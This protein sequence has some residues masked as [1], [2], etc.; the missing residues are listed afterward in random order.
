ML[1]SCEIM[2]GLGNQIFQIF[3]TIAYSIRHNFKFVFP[4]KKRNIDTRMSS[5]YWDNLLKP[6]KIF[7]SNGFLNG[8]M[9]KEPYFKFANIPNFSHITNTLI[10]NG[11]FQSH[12][13]FE[14][15]YKE[16]CKL[17]HLEFQQ[18]KIRELFPNDYDNTVSLHFRIGDYSNLSEHHPVMPIS[19]YLNTLHLL[20][21]KTNRDDWNIL[22]FY[23]KN[24]EARV[25]VMISIM[26]TKFPKLKYTP[27]NHNLED[28]QQLLAMSCCHHQI[29]ANSSFS[30]WGAYFNAN[31]SKIVYYPNVWFGPASSQHD[32]SDLCPESWIKT[33]IR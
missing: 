29:I 20:I 13:Y 10:L 30:W 23:E 17:I 5:L 25:H 2:G 14:S 9:Y 6:L 22:Y 31:P 19:Y 15:E 26:K 12:K 8:N 1:V 33:N 24:D 21:E 3:A 11:Y 32:T 16:I 27:I 28:W 18:N 7:T 4:Y